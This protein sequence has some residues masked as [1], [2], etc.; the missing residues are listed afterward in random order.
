MTSGKTGQYN[1]CYC[2]GSG[3]R[4]DS[5][6]DCN[7]VITLPSIIKVVSVVLLN[8]FLEMQREY[9]NRLYLEYCRISGEYLVNF[10]ISLLSF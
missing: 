10:G 5:Y 3:C 4:Q 2:L 9:K 7:F 8:C 6:N 1:G